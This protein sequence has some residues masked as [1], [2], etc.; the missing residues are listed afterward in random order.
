METYWLFSLLLLPLVGLL[1]WLPVRA[2]RTRRGRVTMQPRD[3]LPRDAQAMYLRLRAA[4]PQY[5]V[6]ARPSLAAFIEVTGGS[7]AAAAARQAEL[8]RQSADFLVCSGDFRI[9]A[10]VEL[11]DIVHG[12]RDHEQAGGLLREAAIPVLR[13]TTVSLPT[14]RDIQEAIAEVETLRL[15][16]IGMEARGNADPDAPAVNWLGRRESRL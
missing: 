6:F 16:N 10:A 8:S 7:K 1:A 12:R 14:I 3:V 13:W 2:R 4:L 15:I 11:E 9:V 5:I